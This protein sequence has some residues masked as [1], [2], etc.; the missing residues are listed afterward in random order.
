M[1]C[2]GLLTVKMPSAEYH[3]RPEL[4]HTAIKSFAQRGPWDF[5]HRYIRREMDAVETPALSLGSAF[6]AAVENADG[7]RELFVEPPTHCNG[8]PLNL[9]KKAHK[10]FLEDWRN[11]LAPGVTVLRR[12]EL[13]SVQKM[14]AAVL[15]NPAAVEYLICPGRKELAGFAVD[16]VSGLKV[17][18][19]ADYLV[20]EF[21]DGEQACSVIVDYKSTTCHT[22]E[23]WSR[24]AIRQL[25]YHYQA[26]WYLDVFGADRFVFVVSRSEPPWEC[27]VRECPKAVIAKARMKNDEV[28]AQVWGCILQDEWHNNGWGGTY[29]MLWEE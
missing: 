11:S 21:S 4:S 23:E 24:K 10:Q 25:G 12:G 18:A 19:M 7:W 9:R 5:Y 16:K 29:E 27:W 22:P 2:E 1:D 14:T 20:P 15:D 28:L 13:G 26:A 6:H 3:S 17:K 8:E